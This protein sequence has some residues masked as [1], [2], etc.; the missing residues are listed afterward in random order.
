VS[1]HIF[2][3]NGVAGLQATRKARREER[4]LRELLHGLNQVQLVNSLADIRDVRMRA[5][6]LEQW[7]RYLTFEPAEN[8]L[9]QAH[10]QQLA[11]LR[12]VIACATPADV[13]EVECAP[14]TAVVSI[15]V[16]HPEGFCPPGAVLAAAAVRNPGVPYLVFVPPG[17]AEVQEQALDIPIPGDEDADPEDPDA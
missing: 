4:R 17:M 2:S 14:C 8:T 11:Q 6:C 1:A 10:E 12:E 13:P 9:A 5:A 15:P 7:R 3:F 16:R